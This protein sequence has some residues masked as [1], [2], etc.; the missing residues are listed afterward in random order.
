MPGGILALSAAGDQPDSGLLWVSL[1][2]ALDANHA[3][4]SGMLRVFDASDVTGE[5]WDSEQV[6]ARDSLG[7]FAKFNPPTVVNGKA[8]VPTF[9][10]QVCVYGKLN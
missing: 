2:V 7:N 4:V 5:L 3:V 8:Y 9:S 6:P 10:N 1:P